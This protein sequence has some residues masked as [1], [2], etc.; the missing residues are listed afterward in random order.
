MNPEELISEGF[1]KAKAGEA[2][3]VYAEVASLYENGELPLR[4]HYSF[5][6]IIYYALHQSPAN[7]IEERKRMLA[8][9]LRLELP[10]PHKLHSMI[11]TE[12]IRLYK[13]ASEMRQI[14]KRKDF[15]SF[16]KSNPFN[17]SI[18][19]FLK[20]WDTSNLR[21]GDWRRKEKDG[22]PLGSTV[23][24]LIT[25][26]VDE[27]ENNNL[28]LP[29]DL[30]PIFRRALK[31][32]PDSSNLLAQSAILCQIRGEKQRAITLLKRALLGE[33]S[34]FYLW[35]RLAGLIDMEDDFK[36]H[37]ALLAKALGASGPETFKGRV[38]IDIA[39]A[40]AF[41]NKPSYAAYEILKVKK[42]YESQGWNLPSSLLQLTKELPGDTIPENPDPIYTSLSATADD[43]IYSE[44]P[45][46]HVRKNY[47]K[48]ACSSTD[49]FGNTRTQPAAWRVE[50]EEGNNLWLTPSRYGIDETLPLST[51]LLVKIFNGKIISAKTFS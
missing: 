1:V 42:L 6:W 35:Q 29:D 26:C 13:N 22:K 7:A 36:L 25:V 17:F 23:E 21:D 14:A 40:W 19:K 47:H 45:E 44:L 5:G 27:L 18:L 34:K 32:Y 20:L 37:I 9:Y 4:R 41:H 31:D 8:R 11:L 30:L 24:K 15:R 38:R 16:I 49:K 33:P 28:T 39:H 50:D 48:S 51:P 10:K 46:I 2:L 43:Y 12:A 3:S